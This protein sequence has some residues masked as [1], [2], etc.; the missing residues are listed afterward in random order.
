MQNKHAI[1][2]D[3]VKQRDQR[4]HM[5]SR[6]IMEVGGGVGS[7]LKLGTESGSGCVSTGLLNFHEILLEGEVRQDN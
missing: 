2:K 7:K 1:L 6:D 4:Q 3:I 5:K